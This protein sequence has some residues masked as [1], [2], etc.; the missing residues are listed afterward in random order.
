[1]SIQLPDGRTALKCVLINLSSGREEI[2]FEREGSLNHFAHETV[3]G[4][5]IIRLRIDWND[6]WEGEPTLDADIF[7]NEAGKAPRKCRNQDW[8]H[9]RLTPTTS[10]DI[11]AYQ[12]QFK[13]LKL[14]LIAR[15][16]LAVSASLDAYIVD[17]TGQSV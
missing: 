16:S 2:L 15:K 14:D 1:M 8:H 5:Y 12:F 11:R 9:T 3:H 7:Q 17:E 6:L 13:D 10:G 4:K